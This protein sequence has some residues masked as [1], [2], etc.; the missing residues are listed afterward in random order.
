[1]D[2]TALQAFVAVAEHHS[3]S[4]AADSLFLTQPAVSKRISALEEELRTAL[5]DRAGRS[6]RL[7]EA[8][9]TLLP[10]ARRVLSEMEASRQAVADLQGRVGG[11]LRIGTSHHIGL[12]RLP[13]ILRSYTAPYPEVE[14]DLPSVSSE[15]WEAWRIEQGYLGHGPDDGPDARPRLAQS[16]TSSTAMKA[17]WGMSTE[18]TFFIR[19]FPSFCC[20]HS[21]RFRVTSPP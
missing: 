12:H 17:S 3:F 20:S 7:T 6:V 8:G 11:R 5:F 1:M 14:L 21:F 13:P 10:H 2:M 15:G 9:T 4:R 18:P 16:P 19:F